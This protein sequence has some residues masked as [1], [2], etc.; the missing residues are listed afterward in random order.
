MCDEDEV[1][2][3]A[4]AKGKSTVCEATLLTSGTF[5]AQPAVNKTAP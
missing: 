5:A 3:G 2:E 4:A 1:P